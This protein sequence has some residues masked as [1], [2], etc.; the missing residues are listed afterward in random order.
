MDITRI[1][2]IVPCYNE[3]EIIGTSVSSLLE[4]LDRYTADGLISGDSFIGIVDDRSTDNTW[5][6][7]RKMTAAS[8]K[9]KAVRLSS[10]RGHQYALLAGLMEFN[11]FAD[12]LI[13]IDAD[14]QDDMLVIGEMIRRFREGNEIVYGVRKDRHNDSMFKRYSAQ[15]FYRI[16]RVFNKQ[17]IFNHAD[18]RL[19][20]RKVLDEFKNFTEVNLYLRGIFPSM[21]F[22]TAIVYYNRKK[23]LA[24]TTKY[25]LKRMVSLALDGITSFSTVPLRMISMIGFLVFLICVILII[26]ALIGYFH[27]RTVPG[28]FSTVLPFYFLGGIQILCIGII[29]EYLG[30]IYKEVKRRPRYIIDDR[31]L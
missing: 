31:I 22:N 9:I 6:I 30:K 26:Y 14:L 19:T 29:G 25:P 12:C 5:E 17:A 13:S 24:G 27:H 7:I 28:W 3:Q 23:R 16:L 2:I 18:F 21:G 15:G 1:G 20:S 4:L 10:N 8:S 11:R